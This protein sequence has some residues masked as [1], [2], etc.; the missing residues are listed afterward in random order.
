MTTLILTQGEVRGLLDMEAC[1]EL[2]EGA[3]RALARDKA[4]NPLRRGMMLAD[5]ESLIGMMPGQMIEPPAIGLKVV[6]VFPQNHGTKYDAHQ[7]VVMLFDP[8]HGLPIAILDGSEVTAIRTAAASGVATRLLAREDA[9]DLAILG[10]GVQA[11]THLEAMRVARDVKR[12]RVFSRRKEARERFATRESERHGIP[13]EAVDSARAAVEGADLI[14][15][16]TSCSEPVVRSEWIADGAHINAVGACVPSAREIDSATVVRS[17]LF[18]D[19]RESAFAESGDFL[20]PRAEGLVTDA[21]ILGEIGELQLGNV[22]GRRSTADVTLFKSL[23][24]AVEDL[25]TAAYLLERA[26]AAGVGTEVALGGLVE[27]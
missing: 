2:V 10:T 21:H 8:E 12:V 15:T 11:R 18:T 6:V 20:I 7:G 14:C 13:V 9:H 1:M 16:T 25:A 27:A 26:R 4:L 19:C 3:L 23:G 24:I 17:L 22:E 5:G